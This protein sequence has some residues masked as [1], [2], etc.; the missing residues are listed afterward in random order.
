M[1]SVPQDPEVE[2]VIQPDWLPRLLLPIQKERFGGREGGGFLM[3]MAPPVDPGR[4]KKKE[5]L[6]VCDQ[7]RHH[8]SAWATTTNDLITQD[9]SVFS[10]GEPRALP[11]VHFLVLA[12]YTL[13]SQERHCL[14]MFRSA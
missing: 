2:R 11:S 10:P 7:S 8:Q 9:G 14:C 12:G 5:Q 1:L 6:G 4:K 13:D 3:A